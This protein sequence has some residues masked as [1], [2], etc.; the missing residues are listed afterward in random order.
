MALRLELSVQNPRASTLEA[1]KVDL[2][3]RNEGSEALD[4]PGP[5]DRTD[6][7]TFEAFDAAGALVVRMSGL[8]SQAMMR[9][10][11]LKEVP[12][13]EQLAP[14]AQW[15]WTLDLA[16]LHYALP[17]RAAAIEAVYRD[18]VSGLEARSERR[19]IE[20]ADL[21]VADVLSVHDDPVIEGLTLLVAAGAN[22][23]REYFL[24][25]HNAPRP[26]AAWYSE[27]V[28]AGAKAEAPFCSA[29]R[30]TRSGS[31]MPSSIMLP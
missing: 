29:E 23:S 30:T 10:G 26:L 9:S 15:A 25:Q 27:R 20:I 8:T 1:L 4:L 28:L 5:D 16:R 31:M 7:L 18:R 12:L 13:L 24:R 21:P 11:R 6:A 14:G 19:T 3:L 22:G 2:V 17:A